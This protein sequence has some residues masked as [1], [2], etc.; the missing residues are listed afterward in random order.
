MPTFSV[1]EKNAKQNSEC[2]DLKVGEVSLTSCNVLAGF[3]SDSLKEQPPR[4]AIQIMV[5]CVMCMLYKLADQQIN[6]YVGVI[7]N[8]SLICE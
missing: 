7:F 4:T 2:V 3:C 8:Y 1:A 6:R 5:A